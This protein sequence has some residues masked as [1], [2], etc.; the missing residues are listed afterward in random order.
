MQS[1]RNVCG[2]QGSEG[3]LRPTGALAP[4]REKMNGCAFT[5]LSKVYPAF[6]SAHNPL[7]VFCLKHNSSQ[8]NTFQ[9]LTI[10]LLLKITFYADDYFILFCSSHINVLLIVSVSLSIKSVSACCRFAHIHPM[11]LSC[12]SS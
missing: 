4:P 5:S 7:F 1:R 9:D 12:Q 2:A 10:R 8:K 11:S 3:L 6:R